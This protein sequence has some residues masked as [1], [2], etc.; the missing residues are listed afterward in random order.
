MNT[1]TPGPWAM[2]PN[3]WKAGKFDIR[4][5]GK[6]LSSGYAPLA[7]V[8]G[9]KRETGGDGEANAR[10]IAAAPTLLMAL[11]FLLEQC[12]GFNVSGVYFNEF[13]E[14]RDAL[15]TAYDAIAKATGAAP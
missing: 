14:S 11:E 15:D 3:P 9:D 7:H 6:G 12:E 4:S 1:H 5:T 2:S 8:Q 10:L 13:R